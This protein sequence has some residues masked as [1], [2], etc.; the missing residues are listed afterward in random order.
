MQLAKNT[1]NANK[2]QYFVGLTMLLKLDR[3][4]LSKATVGLPRCH[5]RAGHWQRQRLAW[6]I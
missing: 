6:I 5:V 3:Q 2:K 4:Q 1:F